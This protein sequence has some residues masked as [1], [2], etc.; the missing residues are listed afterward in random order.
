MATQARID[1]ASI[2][3]IRQLLLAD[4]YRERT[5]ERFIKKHAVRQLLA[6]VM[7][8]RSAGMSFE[9]IAKVFAQGGLEL[10]AETLRVYFFE[11]KTASELAAEAQRHAE[12]VARTRRLIERQRH[13]EHEAHGERVAREF[14]AQT[15]SRANLV[16]ALAAV[17]K[18]TAPSEQGETI[19][20]GQ[21]VRHH[22][23]ASERAAPMRASAQAKTVEREEGGRAADA[24]K[25]EGASADETP[26]PHGLARTLDQVERESMAT[27]ERTVLA[28]DLEVRDGRV[29]TVSGRP[30]A[31]FLNRK[32]I[33][34]LR[35][36]G[37]IIAP[38]AGQSSK[39]F[40]AMPA[41]L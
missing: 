19:E 20:P 27:D 31:G 12:M 3:K 40:V 9:D 13:V 34:L 7:A 18:G 14:V 15:Q 2:E 37:Q 10:S 35:Q 26:L 32:Q 17:S 41:K 33:L 23:G 36:V 6:P 39:D 30:F 1:K 38:V 5:D 29:Y 25:S 24:A 21:A 8:A 16:T 28:E 22:A 4:I 11:L